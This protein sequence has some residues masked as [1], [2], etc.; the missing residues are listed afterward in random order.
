MNPLLISIG[1]LAVIV[2]PCT[3]AYA[4]LIWADKINRKD[5]R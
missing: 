3:I 4:V 1:A 2:L 5:R